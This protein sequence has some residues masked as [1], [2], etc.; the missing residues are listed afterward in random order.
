VALVELRGVTKVYRMKDV[1][2]GALRGI[3]LAFHQGEFVSI[4]GP[5]GSGK[6]TLLSILGCLDRPTDGRYILSGQ[7]VS[8][9]TDDELSR[10][11]NMDIGF[12]FQSFNLIQQ[13]TVL[14]NVEVPLF[15]RGLAP[16]ERR[17]KALAALE[18]VGLSDRLGH[19]PSELSGGQCQRVAIARAL[20]GDPVITL[21][22][23]PT[24]NLD[25]KT[26]HEIIGVLHELHRAGRTILMVTHDES[27]AAQADRI[28][29]LSD[30][31]VVSTGGV[32][33]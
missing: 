8:T 5:S 19:I 31:L 12:I 29:R 17:D 28:V 13:L 16:H 24:G 14:E 15:Y 22:D 23:E 33:A 32:A 4:M 11:R 25:S 26:G 27:L 20:V 2:V 9:A 18:R 3:D 1:E 21:A 30:G 6:S 7:D 10:V